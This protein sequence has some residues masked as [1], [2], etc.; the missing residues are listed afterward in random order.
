MRLAAVCFLL[1]TLALP[2]SAGGLQAGDETHSHVVLAQLVTGTPEQKLKKLLLPHAW[3]GER[4][5]DDIRRATG[6]PDIP[7]I[8]RRWQWG[9]IYSCNYVFLKGRQRGRALVCE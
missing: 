6:D 5:T 9:E 1:V 2:A 4:V 3:Y 8:D 7:V